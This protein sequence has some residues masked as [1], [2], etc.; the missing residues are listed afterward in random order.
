MSEWGCNFSRIS[1]EEKLRL[2]FKLFDFLSF[3]L[4]D[5]STTKNNERD[6]EVLIW[7]SERDY[8]T[9]GE[10]QFSPLALF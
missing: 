3:L 2:G 4:Y 10:G 1:T 7:K 8:I 6:R 9:T 5:F